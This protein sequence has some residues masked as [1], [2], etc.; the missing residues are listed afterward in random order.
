MSENYCKDCKFC[1]VSIGAMLLFLPKQI[2]VHPQN[3]HID[4]VTGKKK[5]ND[6]F[7]YSVRHNHCGKAGHWFEPKK[8]QR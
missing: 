4:V 8:T 3:Y 7:C 5:V 6:Y 2:C 1:K